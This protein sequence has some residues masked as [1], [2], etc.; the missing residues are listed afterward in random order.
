MKLHTLLLNS[1]YECIGFI[2]WKK[3]AKL[4]AKDKVEVLSSWKDQYIRSGKK[5]WPHPAVIRM[6][7]R[8]RWIPKKMRYSKYAVFKRDQFICGYCGIK[9]NNEN[10]TLDH[11]Y[12]KSQGGKNSFKNCVTSCF[13]CNNLKQARTPAQ[14]GMTLRQKPCSPILTAAHEIHRI[15]PVH[16]AWKEYIV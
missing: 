7:Y 16:E 14:A 4:L 8:V 1:T 6:K 5:A 10:A 15:Q 2:G 12:P 11:I 9:L 3:A 13:Q